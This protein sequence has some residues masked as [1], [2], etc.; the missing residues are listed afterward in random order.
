M[1]PSSAVQLSLPI[2]VHPSKLMPV[3]KEIQSSPG[4]FAPWNGC[5]WGDVFAGL[6]LRGRAFGPV[7]SRPAEA[8]RADVEWAVAVGQLLHRS[9]ARALT[10]GLLAT[11]TERAV[12]VQTGIPLQP[13]ERFWNAL[14]VRVPGLAADL[15]EAENILYASAA[16][17]AELLKAAQRLHQIAHP[18]APDKV[19]TGAR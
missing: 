17:E 13:R 12:S 10:L 1:S 3:N 9:S 18:A 4:S 15:A 16:G 19:T 14:W 7:I 11:A 2:F 5:R 8:A 6:L